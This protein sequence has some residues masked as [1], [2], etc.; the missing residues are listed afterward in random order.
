MK[1]SSKLDYLA[2]TCKS[3]KIQAS[4]EA[5]YPLLR[6]DSWL[7]KEGHGNRHYDKRYTHRNGVYVFEHTTRPGQG[8][9]VVYGGEA[10]D[11]MRHEIGF[12]GWDV[13]A[14]HHDQGHK[15]K[16]VDVAVD[17]YG[18]EFRIGDFEDAFESGDCVTYARK[19]HLDR[20]HKNGATYYVGSRQKRKKLLR[21][22]DKGTQL[23]LDDLLMRI[24]FESQKEP[25][26]S[27][28]DKLMS[29]SDKHELIVGLIR[30]FA[31]FPTIPVWDKVMK[32]EPRKVEMPAHKQ[33]KTELWLLRQVAPAFAREMLSNPDIVN[34][35]R[36][37]VEA[38]VVKL[39]A[40][41]KGT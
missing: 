13:L 20:E 11:N 7:W 14:Y 25:A 31:D 4:R 28:A 39:T 30:G 41:P 36:D 23:G 27:V 8:Y 21:V 5:T 9:H 32:A 37:A 2:I 35:F 26:Q 22:Y 6:L 19:A 16:R 29:T 24:E 10:L 18:E 34:K 33:G 12:D 15:I 38:N 40:P 1:V 3:P 17:V